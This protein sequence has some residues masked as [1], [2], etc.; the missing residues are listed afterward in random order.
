MAF[1]LAFGSGAL[2]AAL[3]VEL[4][5]GAVEDGH[6]WAMTLGAVLGGVVFKVL[7]ALVNRGGGY[8]RRWPQTS[9]PRRPGARTSSG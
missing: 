3:A 4:V 8:L 6:I 9:P 5:A 1:F 2:I 7:N